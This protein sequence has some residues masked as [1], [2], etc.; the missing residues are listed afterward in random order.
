MQILS[1]NINGKFYLINSKIFI[2]FARQYDILFICETHCSKE[3]KIELEG[4]KSYQNPCKLS[5]NKY[6]RGGT[7]MYV[8]ENLIKF[9]SEVNISFNDIIILSLTGNIKI[10]GMYIPPRDSLY[11]DN[12]FKLFDLIVD[13]SNQLNERLIILGDLNARIG[14]QENLCGLTYDKNP[15][16]MINSHGNKLISIIQD[17]DIIPINNLRTDQKW[18]DSNFTFTC[19]EI[20]SQLDW[21]LISKLHINSIRD[22][23]VVSDYP[24]ISDHNPI[25]IITEVDMSIPL[26]MLLYQI[27]D[28]TNRPNN[29]SRMKKYKLNTINKELFCNNK[30]SSTH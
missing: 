21:C 16:P 26:E 29:H 22:F 15:D 4:Y 14:I 28:L 25:S 9:I 1:W 8:K 3:V 19:G 24:K 2:S 23:K 5:S 18:F 30:L 20:K 27:N 10:C 13:T 17:K 6:P 7:I 11:F 12:Q